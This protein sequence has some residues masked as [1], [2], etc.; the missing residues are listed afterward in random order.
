MNNPGFIGRTRSQNGGGPIQGLTVTMY[1][2]MG[3]PRPI[4]ARPRSHHGEVK[5]TKPADPLLLEKYKQNKKNRD[6]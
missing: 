3:K 4:N 5:V 1:L 2:Y 6:K